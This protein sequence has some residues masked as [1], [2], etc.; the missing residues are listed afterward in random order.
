MTPTREH[1]AGLE[2]AL[3]H[4]NAGGPS[5][6]YAHFLDYLIAQAKAAPELFTRRDTRVACD[7]CGEL[8][9][10]LRAQVHECGTAAPEPVQG[11]ATNK[12]DTKGSR[13]ALGAMNAKLRAKVGSLERELAAAKPDAELVALVAEMRRGIECDS[14][15]HYPKDY[16]DHDEPCPVLARI[17]AKLA[18]MRKVAP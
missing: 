18:E 12:L 8:L 1:I 7:M 5:V 10:S 13:K 11:E 6:Q 9:G 2:L 17:D 4:W 16:H 3:H 15:H 14:V